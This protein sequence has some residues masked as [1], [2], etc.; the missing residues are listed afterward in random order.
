MMISAFSGYASSVLGLPGPGGPASVNRA[1]AVVA[2]GVGADGLRVSV[3]ANPVS[4]MGSSDADRRG[5]VGADV[6]GEVVERADRRGNLRTPAGTDDYRM[7]YSL[8]HRVKGSAHGCNYFPC[9]C[10]F[11]L[12]ACALSL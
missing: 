11:L 9:A 1:G 3:E 12:T 4:A 2:V 10:V 6:V 7:R 8:A 5:A